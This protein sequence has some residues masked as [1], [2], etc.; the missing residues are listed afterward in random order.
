MTKE[1]PGALASVQLE[2]ARAVTALAPPLD[3]LEGGGENASRWVRADRGIQAGERLAVYANA[4]FARLHDALRD[5]LPVL[6]RVLGD[7]GFHDLVKLYLMT[8]PPRGFSLRTLG[9]SLPDFLAGP[10][11]EPFRRRWPFAPDLAAFEWALV[12]VFDARDTPL[13]V[14]HDLEAVAPDEW[15]GLRFAPIEAHRLLTVAWPVHRLR[16]AWEGDL[17]MPSLAPDRT[18][19]LVVRRGDQV[20][21]RELGELEAKALAGVR[22]GRDFGAV[23]ADVAAVSGETE[24]PIR[25]LEILERWIGE[26]LLARLHR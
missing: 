6:H 7:A 18:H 17:P 3:A 24:G 15:V 1:R 11:G 13:L 19:L 21:R 22:E 5:D 25:A 10:L 16:D 9:E 20:F 8:H 12:D 23:C 2:L 26:G 14:R 4:Y